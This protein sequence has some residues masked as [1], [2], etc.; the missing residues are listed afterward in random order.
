MNQ[1]GP[2]GG[3]ESLVDL[4]REQS[5]KRPDALA[6]IST[7]TAPPRE[8]AYTY[9]ELARAAGSLASKLEEHSIGAGDYVGLIFE[10]WC[11]GLV[12]ALFA[13]WS[14]GCVV[15]PI[16]PQTSALELAFVMRHSSAAAILSG[17]KFESLVTTLRLSKGAIIVEQEA[18]AGSG[19]SRG[20]LATGAGGDDI[21]ACLY[22]S[23]TTGGPKG[24]LLTH[25]NLLASVSAARGEVIDGEGRVV[26]CGWP[27]FHSLGLSS[28]LLL[29]LSLGGTLAVTNNLSPASI[30]NVV[31]HRQG[32]VLLAT[33]DVYAAMPDFD[34]SYPRK[35]PSLSDCVSCGAPLSEGV[36]K[37]FE[38]AYGV[39]IRDGFGLTE[40]SSIVSVNPK[41]WRRL[42]SVGKP[43]HGIAIR[44]FGGD[45]KPLIPGEIGEIV[46]KG[47]VLM[48]SYLGDQEATD[49]TLRDGWL[50]TGDLGYKDSDGYIYVL[51]RADELITVSGMKVFPREVEDVLKGHPDIR[52]ACAVGLPDR[53]TGQAIKV[54][55]VR[56]DGSTVD[57]KDV[58]NIC[59]ESLIA[60]KV[61]KYV[62]FV[63]GLPKTVTGKIDIDALL[64]S[65]PDFSPA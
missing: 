46:I 20:E 52:D 26:V 9:S 56:A 7:S 53:E 5:E 31:R 10:S 32:E 65:D 62:Q 16:R 11:P 8:Y 45:S 28:G 61:P 22:T 40:A 34:W 43:L 49:Q 37:K 25:A 19:G 44:V 48:A 33:P 38:R 50:R 30:L 4:L 6:L 12:P 18:L 15:V 14:A 47:D 41:T 63:E 64:A 39:T 55:V 13:A 58:Q 35:L 21:A 54:Y 2:S 23:G 29:S 3:N 17:P 57:C 24:V 1:G 59:R 27:P 42:G 36:A 51:G 60:N